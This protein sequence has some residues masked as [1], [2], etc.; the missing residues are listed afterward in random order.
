MKNIFLVLNYIL[1][2]F[3][4]L[5]TFTLI[6][7]IHNFNNK[8]GYRFAN[9]GLIY[10]GKSH[11]LYT[12]I[13]IDTNNVIVTFAVV[14]GIKNGKFETF[15]LDGQLEGTGSIINNKNEGEW[16]YYYKSGQIECK[17]YFFNDLPGG[18]WE[19]YYENGKLKSAGEYAQGK[20][21]GLW[22]FY[23]KKGKLINH[24]S[25]KNG[26]FFNQMFNEV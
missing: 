12:G 20:M 24:V 16:K 4:T 15:Y 23:D 1:V 26:F 5:L 6:S 8:Q 19:Y 11:E 3:I 2:F 13:I 21:I 18:R 22:S 10:A 14:K 25:Y 7:T 17:G 9:D